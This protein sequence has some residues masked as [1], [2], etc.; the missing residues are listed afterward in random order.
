MT[1]QR[2]EGIVD[3]WDRERGYGFIVP[4]GD[5][6]QIYVEASALEGTHVLSCEQHVSF[7][8]QF[9]GGR[10]QARSVRP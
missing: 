1:E 7:L 3:W 6:D 2:R 5:T 4:F 9:T 8:L 10:F